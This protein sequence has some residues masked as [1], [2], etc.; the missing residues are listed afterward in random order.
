MV[1]LPLSR[2]RLSLHTDYLI[3]TPSMIDAFRWISHI[4]PIRYAFEG[5]MTNSF[6]TLDG[7]CSTLVPSGPGYEGIFVG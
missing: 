2:K 1:W 4:N 7:V 6:Y 3:P 5:L